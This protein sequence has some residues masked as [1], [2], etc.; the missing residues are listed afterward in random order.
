VIRMGDSRLHTRFRWADL[1]EEDHREDLDV[2]G[3]II[4]KL[5]F[6]KWDRGHEFH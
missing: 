3:T 1:R 4:F 5:T 2:D 6:K